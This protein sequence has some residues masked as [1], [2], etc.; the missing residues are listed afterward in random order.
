[1]TWFRCFCFFLAAAA[2]CARP[3]AEEYFAKAQKEERSAALAADTL[4][5]PVEVR[6]AF[7]PALGLFESVVREYP[8]H[9]LAETALFEI[10]SIKNSNLHTPQEAIDAYNR[11]CGEYP[12]GKQ[13]ALAMFMIGYLY[14][15]ELH[16]NDSAAAANRRFLERFPESEMA[17]SAQFELNTLGKSP[18]EA[19][20]I[21]V[22]PETKKGKKHASKEPA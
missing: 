21:P 18:E 10:A 2:G 9:E 13:T 7:E 4:R 20:P 14:N 16:N 6:R 1:M 12:A 3:T 22:E 19:L 8:H 11:Y 5:S 15:N 17:S